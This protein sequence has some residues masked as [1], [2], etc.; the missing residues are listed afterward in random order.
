VGQQERRGEADPHHLG[1]VGLRLVQVDD[2]AAAGQP[3]QRQPQ[4]RRHRAD[5]D[6]VRAGPPEQAEHR[7]RPPQDVGREPDQPE[8]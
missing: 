5:V 4:R 7:R 6:E 2:D 3:R 8:R 1:D